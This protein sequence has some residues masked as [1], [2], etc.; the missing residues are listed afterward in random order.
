MY[1]GDITPF[2]EFSLKTLKEELIERIISPTD[3]KD[4]TKPKN[5]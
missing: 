1:R 2:L 3:E 4:S 5:K